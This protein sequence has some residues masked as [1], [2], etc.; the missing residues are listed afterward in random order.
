[1]AEKIYRKGTVQCSQ[2]WGGGA[3]VEYKIVKSPKAVLGA[4]LF[5]R[6]KNRKWQFHANVKPSISRSGI[7]SSADSYVFNLGWR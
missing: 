7:K 2:R 5:L 3:K 1:M 6:A 4:S